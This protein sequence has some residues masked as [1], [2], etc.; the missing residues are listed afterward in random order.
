MTDKVKVY[1]LDG[2]AME[3]ERGQCWFVDRSRYKQ[4]LTCAQKRYFQYH[5]QG[6]GVDTAYRSED[7][8]L[9]SAVHTG[10]EVLMGYS[11][12]N[13][14]VPEYIHVGAAVAAREAMLES[15][16][17]GMA[18]QDDEGFAG[19]LPE[20]AQ[21]LAEEQ[22]AL[23]YALV[24]TFGRRHLASLLERYEVV[25]VEPE[26]CWLVR[27]TGFANV[28]AEEWLSY[29]ETYQGQNGMDVGK[30]VVMMSRPDA[31]LRS[32]ETGKLWVVSWKTTKMFNGESVEK[33]E[34]D[35]QG[36]TEGLAVQAMYGEE[37]GGTF[38]TYLVKGSKYFSK[39]DGVKRYTTPLVRP[40]SLW[41]GVGE[42]RYSVET[43]RTKGWQRVDVWKGME[44]AEW[45]SML[46]AWST[47][48]PLAEAVAEP[49]PVPLNVEAA[50]RWVM[51][52]LQGES[53]WMKIVASERVAARNTDSCFNFSKRCSY[54]NICHR[55]ETVEEQ[56]A[57][58]RKVMRVSNH[59]AEQG[60]E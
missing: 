50:E 49:L 59:P 57:S 8:A 3:L 54:F 43:E 12:L 23:A 6:Q 31:V 18:L 13:G 32:R 10:L 38:Y 7:L 56:L 5:W 29:W 60:G 19:V 45:M 26:I 16:A 22:A 27:F 30:A 34:C 11:L 46:D 33:L 47:S 2:P 4:G 44:M 21:L 14:E 36:L 28:S 9:G 48:D 24:W 35:L 37:V 58:G 39:E 53:D 15:A 55:G 52:A 51:E 25:A 1:R 17:Q 41:T 42:P 20:M 40:Y